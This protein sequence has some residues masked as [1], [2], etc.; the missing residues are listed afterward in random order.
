MDRRLWALR[1]CLRVGALRGLAVARVPVAAAVLPV[2]LS[3]A[4]LHLPARLGRLSGAEAAA[5]A[6]SGALTVTWLACRGTWAGAWLIQDSLAVALLLLVLRSV[7]LPSVRVACVLLPLCL[8]YDVW[9]VFLQ[10]AVTAGRESVMVVVA[11]G[12]GGADALPLL[13]RVPRLSG[14]AVLSGGGSLLGFGDVIIP[15]LLC[16][17][18]RRLALTGWSGAYF[19][20]SVVGYGAGLGLTYVALACSW[21]GP[22][23]QPALLYLV[24]CTLGSVLLLGAA[25]RELSMLLAASAGSSLLCGTTID[26]EAVAGGEVASWGTEN[27]DG[28]CRG[29]GETTMARGGS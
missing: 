24:P 1:G 14:P 3:H 5:A 8:V 10:P 28:S 22:D 18:T 11:S 26:Y 15:G 21:F 7:R 19:A 23:G 9:W 20:V 29:G 12:A 25:R 13:L 27:D 17:L 16:A 2:R 6:T 4:T